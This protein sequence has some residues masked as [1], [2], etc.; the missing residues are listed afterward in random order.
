M[1]E[2]NKYTDQQVIQ[3]VLDGDTA[4]FEIIIRRNNPFIYK[5]GRSY[6]Y[7]HEDTQDL[8][9]DTFVDAFMNLSKFENRSAL[10]TWLIR[11]MLNNCNK[12]M[13]KYSFKNEFANEIDDTSVP[14]FAGDNYSDTSNTV[15]NRELNLVIQKALQQIPLD[16]RLV[17]SL[18]EI[19][20]LNVSET[21]EALDIS[22]TNVKVRLNRAKAMMRKEV[23]KSYTAEEI[24]DFNL[25]YC[26]AI[27]TRVMLKIK[28]AS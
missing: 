11:I 12:R 6:N 8:M 17:F 27:V 5:V 21:A 3:K 7:N 23:E 4:L 14:M 1:K 28:E 13:K 24:F 20:G 26:D 9:Q 16:Y 19:N 15:M 18:R 22:S 2:Y 25:I 10:K